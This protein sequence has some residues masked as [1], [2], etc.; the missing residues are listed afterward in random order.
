MCKFPQVGC[1]QFHNKHSS[2]HCEKLVYVFLVGL[3]SESKDE[4]RSRPLRLRVQKGKKAYQYPYCEQQLPKVEPTHV[5]ELEQDPSTEML[6]AGVVGV[7]VGALVEVLDFDVVRVLVVIE[8]LLAMVVIFEVEEEVL[9]VEEIL[10]EE[11][12]EVEEDL[13]DEV[14]LENV[15][16]FLRGGYFSIDLWGKET[17]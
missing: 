16:D 10:V 17:R 11:V 8:V 14:A 7:T 9:E 12:L 15:L 1:I 13:E 5:I 4:T 2:I 6:D 3:G